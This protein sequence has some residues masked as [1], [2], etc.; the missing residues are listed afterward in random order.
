MSA[1]L[2]VRT[3]VAPHVLERE[4]RVSHATTSD[5]QLLR[6]TLSDLAGG[7]EGVG[8]ISADSSYGQDAPT[9]EREARRLAE[10]IAA[11]PRHGE[12]TALEQLL[13]DHGAAF[14]GPARM[15]A[16]MAFLDRIAQLAGCP[17]WHV[18]GLPQPGRVQLLHTVPIGEDVSVPVRPLK[19]KLGGGT[20]ADI[21]AQ[22]IGSPGP[23]L[24][25]VNE[26]WDRAGWGRVED[27][28]RKLAPA[29]LEDPTSDTG[30][31]QEI[32]AALPETRV[33]LDESVQDHAH[34]VRA[35]ELADGANLKV[36]RMGGLFP[37]M[38]SLAYLR[39]RG[40][41]RMIGSFLE[42]A[43]AVAYAA[44]L[45]GLADWTDLDGHFWITDTPPVMH[46]R[47]DSSRPGVPVIAYDA[48][49]GGTDVEG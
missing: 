12:V 34:V 40:L 27:L 19:A 13:G 26:G 8:E 18:L 30:L 38:R 7:P 48:L 1:P 20:D 22:L 15:L 42:P 17:V 3:S 10:S 24:L 32:R 49:R 43:R 36:M 33:V 46:Y 39:E 35:A 44:Q 4:F 28:V 11:D 2:T 31:L 6:L 41:T 29:V 25:D 47:L 5:V 9:I 16:E 37:A 14:C 45:N 23:I 21:L